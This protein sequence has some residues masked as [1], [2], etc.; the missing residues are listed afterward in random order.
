MSFLSVELSN[1]ANS[2][3]YCVLVRYF[4]SNEVSARRERI[5]VRGEYTG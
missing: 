4:L 2:L 1:S 3:F 5:S